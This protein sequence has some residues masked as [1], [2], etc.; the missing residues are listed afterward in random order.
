MAGVQGEST[1]TGTDDSAEIGKFTGFS[2]KDGEVQEAPKK[3]GGVAQGLETPAQ[4]AAAAKAAAAAKGNDDD[5]EGTEKPDKTEQH[6]SA[7]DRIN[8]AVAKQRNAERERDDL[9]TG[10]DA[11]TKR[12][13]ALEA[14]L[15]AGTATPAQRQ[16]AKA[17]AAK[18][19]GEP[20]AEE[21]E[22]GEADIKFIRDTARWEVKQELAEQAAAKKQ[23]KKAKEQSNEQQETGKAW[24]T[25][26]AAGAEKFGDDYEDT[27]RNEDLKVGPTLAALLLD[28][29]NGV[30]IAFD[31]ASDPELGKKVSAMTVARQAAWFGSYEETNYPSPSGDA[32]EEDEEKV[33]KPAPKAPPSKPISRAP[34]PP[35]HKNRGGGSSESASA[36]TDDFAAFERMAKTQR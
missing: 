1:D 27:V 28:S 14:R 12:L 35:V 29:L 13:D 32:E 9:R 23:D 20:K 21:Y 6:K 22:F 7:Q 16:E 31:I 33:A 24:A 8:K 25:F 30:D 3:S 10:N 15:S 36:D 5:D 18:V 11:L 17:Q 26:F 2:V 4:K 19:D 34:K